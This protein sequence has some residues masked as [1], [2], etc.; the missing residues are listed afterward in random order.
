MTT[1]TRYESH[2]D[3]AERTDRPVRARGARRPKP[4]AVERSTSAC[5][6]GDLSNAGCRPGRSSVEERLA[7]VFGV[8]RTKIRQALARLAHDGIVTV[9][10][11]RG[12]FVTQPD[13]SR[14]R[15]R[16]SRRAG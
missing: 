14:R 8:S 6:N 4:L 2:A 7:A 9:F 3:G 12:A 11:N 5:V 1:K 16:C 13:A 15:A 10:P